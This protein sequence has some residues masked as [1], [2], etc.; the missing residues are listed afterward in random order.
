M[1]HELGEEK[2]RL[3]REHIA[4]CEECQKE[5]SRLR[6]FQRM[7]SSSMPDAVDQ[8]LLREAREQLHRSLTIV[9]G[10]GSVLDRAR[11]F[12]LGGLRPGLRLAT[13]GS[14]TFIV[15]MA[16]SYGIFHRAAQNSSLQ[17]IQNGSIIAAGDSRISNVRFLN[18]DGSN[19]DVEFTFETVRPVR[20]KGNI[21]DPQIEKVLAYAI[22]NEDNPG[23][24]LQSINAVAAQRP[25]DNEV[26]KALISALRIDKNAGVRRE[27]LRALQNFPMDNDIKDAILYVLNHDGN[28]GM[29]VAAINLLDSLRERSVI[30]N[31]DLLEAFEKTVQTD[32]NNYI[33]LRAKAAI[34]EIRQ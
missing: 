13:I 34:E 23:V 17:D 21:R 30:P 12:L 7:L 19:G 14:A 8:G 32:Q 15:G 1:F 29:R 11:D 4:G 9:Q 16:V 2:E 27:S 18:A 26:K 24:R 20:M 22:L 31:K 33:R 6:E 25:G 3:L 5:E 28:P 10:S